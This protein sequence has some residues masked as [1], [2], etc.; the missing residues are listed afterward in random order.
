MIRLVN[1]AA[2]SPPALAEVDWR[3]DP[4]WLTHVVDALGA[5]GCAVVTG[6]LDEAL[7]AKTR[8]AMYDVQR[9][10]RDDVGEERLD[11]GRASSACCA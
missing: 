4:D 3:Q 7:L 11:A 5:T 9:Q 1:R 8:E 2:E 10:I 6:V